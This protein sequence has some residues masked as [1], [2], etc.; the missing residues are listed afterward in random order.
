MLV[1]GDLL[2]VRV[3]AR[4]Y[5]LPVEYVVETMRPLACEHIASAPAYVRGASIV[6][7]T[8][9]PIVD[10]GELLGD[11]AETTRAR[12]VTLRVDAERCVGLLVDEVLG[13]RDRQSIPAHAL[14]PLLQ[15]ADAHTVEELGTLDGQLLTVL[16]AGNLIPSDV[17]D[18]SALATEESP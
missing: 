12:L 16:Q 11:T 10:L 6:R 8:S 15:S 4:L 3:G 1:Q 18:S 13:L 7:G 14:P 5:A 17:W 2:L 9:I